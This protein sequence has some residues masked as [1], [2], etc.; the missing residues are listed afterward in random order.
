VPGRNAAVE[1]VIVP[2][3]SVP[4]LSFV[5]PSKKVTVPEGVGPKVAVTVAVNV[6]LWPT[7]EVRVEAVSAVAVGARMVNEKL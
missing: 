5:L 4:A 1:Y 6:T 3:F 2:A 7:T